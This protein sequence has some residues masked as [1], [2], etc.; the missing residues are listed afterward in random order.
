MT[1]PSTHLAHIE[2]LPYLEGKNGLSRTITYFNG[3]LKTLAGHS[4]SKV[5]I[6]VK[7]DGSPAIFFGRDA[8]GQFF[9]ATKGILAKEPKLNYSVQDIRKNHPDPEL[10]RIMET[11]LTHLAHI[12][13]KGDKTVW[14]GDYLYASADLKIQD[15]DGEELLTFT[16]NTITYAV[17]QQSHLGKMIRM[18]AMGIV[19][20]TS[21]KDLSMTGKK[22]APKLTFGSSLSVWVTTPEFQDV[23]GS[24][25]LTKGES[26]IVDNMVAKLSSLQT[27]IGPSLIELVTSSQLSGAILKWTNKMVRAGKDISQFSHAD[28][29]KAM[30]DNLEAELKQSKL[31]LERLS[32]LRKSPDLNKLLQ[33]QNIT[34]LVKK[35]FLK[36]LDSSTGLAKTFIQDKEG[37]KVT[38]P[39]GYVAIDHTGRAIKLVDRLNFS[40]LNFEN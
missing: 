6:S 29:K 27:A 9:V 40:R 38:T 4:A 7:F 8:K 20:H 34:V 5:N 31:G 32:R 26:E 28:W 13:P 24:A 21:Y 22:F 39:E 35:I 12:I 10:Q 3:L 2:D 36:K 11:A 14:Q 33:F 1:G 19:V 25:T 30:L 37:F 18:S 16:P 15:I 23:S 17:P